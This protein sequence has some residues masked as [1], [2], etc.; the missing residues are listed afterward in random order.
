MTEE[1]KVQRSTQFE[2]H[3]GLGAPM[4]LQ[5]TGTDSNIKSELVGLA[6]NEFLIIRMPLIPGARNIFVD[7]K[8]LIVRYLSEGT[9]FGFRAYIL[10][11]VFKPA[12]LVFID[13]PTEVEKIDL[14]RYK[15]AECAL[16]CK[17]HS[18]GGIIAGILLDLSEGGCKVSIKNEEAETELWESDDM[19]VLECHLAGD[20]STLLT[21]IVRS[22]TPN[23][24]KTQLG[25]QFETLDPGVKGAINTYVSEL[26]KQ[27][28]AW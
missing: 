1:Q 2:L 28:R 22:I 21:G 14:R 25:L 19:L 4:L 10:K 16:P 7:G 18:K 6:R 8:Q 12:P 20:D 15:R 17:V 26:E 13:Y 27:T 9:I 5:A 11:S 3:V 23:K 24:S